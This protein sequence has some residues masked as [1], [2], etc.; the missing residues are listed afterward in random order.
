MEGLLDN[1]AILELKKVGICFH[2]TA[3]SVG[4]LVYQIFYLNPKINQIV[5]LDDKYK[6]Q[7]AIFKMMQKYFPL[8]YDEDCEI[9]MIEIINYFI[10]GGNVKIIYNSTDA[11]SPYYKCQ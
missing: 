7:V 4:G 6:Q 8:D 1:N 9:K 11:K 2:K 10:S 5:K 3:Q